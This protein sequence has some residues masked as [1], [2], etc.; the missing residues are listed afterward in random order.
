MWTHV[1]QR[2]GAPAAALIGFLVTSQLVEGTR[3]AE[4]RTDALPVQAQRLLTV[5]QRLLVQALGKEQPL[6]AQ[7]PSPKAPALPGLDDSLLPSRVGIVLG[8][9]LGTRWC[10]GEGQ[11]RRGGS[12]RS[13]KSG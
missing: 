8:L 3:L 11:G 9:G 13:E 12:W 4:E 5:L 6:S 1:G 7:S 2:K 10:G